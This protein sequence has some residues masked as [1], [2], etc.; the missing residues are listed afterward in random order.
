MQA[1]SYQSFVRNVS[2]MQPWGRVSF[3]SRIF[4]YF[5]VH[6]EALLQLIFSYKPAGINKAANNFL[7]M[8]IV[9]MGSSGRCQAYIDR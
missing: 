3:L 7:R 1:I 5:D 8:A 2:M 6:N 9:I 4:S